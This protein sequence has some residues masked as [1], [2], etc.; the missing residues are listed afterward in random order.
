MLEARC[1]PN[2]LPPQ[3]ALN[4]AKVLLEMEFAKPKSVEIT[5]LAQS[6]PMVKPLTDDEI[7]LFNKH[8]DADY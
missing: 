5:G 2:D 6:T 7:E 3:A 4:S 1:A 8:F